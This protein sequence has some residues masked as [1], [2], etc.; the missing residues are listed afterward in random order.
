MPFLPPTPTPTFYGL[1]NVRFKW[2]THTPN[3]D[4]LYSNKG[5]DVEISPS[6]T[7]PHNCIKI[8]LSVSNGN[9]LLMA[10]TG[11]NM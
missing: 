10:T 6:N 3:I 8:P 11:R 4:I 7:P 5:L 9:D 1:M 2:F